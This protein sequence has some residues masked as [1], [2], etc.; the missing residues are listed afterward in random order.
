MRQN[1]LSL[2]HDAHRG[3]QAT[4]HR[5]QQT[6]WW[7]GIN[8]YITTTVEP[9]ASCQLLQPSQQREPLLQSSQPTR[10]FEVTS[11]DLFSHAG[12]SY[13][14]YAD[15]YTGW[16]EVHP[17]AKDTSSNATMRAFRKFFCQLGIPTHLRTDGGPQFSSLAFRTF[18]KS[19]S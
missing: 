6:V 17:F 13:L 7:P 18:L 14:L 10:P 15:R 3:V 16:P 1:V 11:A 2:L 19:K 9:Y 5:A 4:K 8:N 12:R